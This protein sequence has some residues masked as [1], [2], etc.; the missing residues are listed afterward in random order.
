MKINW[1]QKY[2]TMAVYACATAFIIITVICLF[3]NFD[4]TKA[5][6]NNIIGVLAPVLY[7]FCFAYLLFPLYK[8]FRDRIFSR[9]GSTTPRRRLRKALALV[10]SYLCVISFITV[11]VLFVIPQIIN[12]YSDLQSRLG[13][14]FTTLQEW[15]EEQASGSNLFADQYKKLLEYVDVS[16]L[17]EK[18]HQFV[19]DS[20]DVVVSGTSYVFGFL[21]GIVTQIKNIA[22]GFIISVYMILWQEKLAAQAKK[23]LHALFEKKAVDRVTELLRNT[24]RTFGGFIVGKLIDSLIIGILTFVVLGIFDIPY[25]PLISVIIGVTNIIPFFGPFIGAIPSAFIIFVADPMKALWFIIIIIIIQQLD[26]NLIGPRILGNTTGL[27]ALWIIIAIIVMNGFLGLTGLFF[28]V[29]IFA[30]LYQLIKE[31]TEAR[32]KK[33]GL[34]VSTESYYSGSEID[35]IRAVRITRNG[36]E[37]FSAANTEPSVANNNITDSDI[38][39]KSG[40]GSE[41]GD[42]Q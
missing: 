13:G 20:F 5:V 11:F 21:S 36:A 29:P 1:N 8:F 18:L 35:G 28:G 12:S 33:R 39:N 23:L 14:Y 24:D 26:G 19:T 6:I 38:I 3:V 7:G 41:G 16:N 22:F 30:V 42:E 34:P 9:I 4:S 25:Y 27:D 31:S 2:N 32:L 37:P 15:L 40:T 17:S 10:C